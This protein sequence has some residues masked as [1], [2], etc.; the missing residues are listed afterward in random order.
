M[1]SSKAEDAIVVDASV[2]AK[3]FIE[4]ALSETA[5]DLY[6]RYIFH[7]PTLIMPELTNVFWKY[8]QLKKYPADAAEAAISA[9]GRQLRLTELTQLATDALRLAVRLGHPAYDCFYLA[10]A[11]QMKIPFLTADKKLLRKIKSYKSVETIS[12]YNVPEAF[13]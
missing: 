7:A 4:D 11:A 13:R 9:V 2:A 6:R 1:P 5:A 12:L 8:V 3:I 10:L